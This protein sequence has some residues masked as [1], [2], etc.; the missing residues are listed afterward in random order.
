MKQGHGKNLVSFK[1][2]CLVEK[3]IKIIPFKSQNEK[4]EYKKNL[5]FVSKDILPDFKSED[6]N[7][8]K[9]KTLHCCVE[10]R[11]ELS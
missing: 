9:A 7:F 1:L 2:L 3:V 11:K 8:E 4:N 6:P 10:H 5:I